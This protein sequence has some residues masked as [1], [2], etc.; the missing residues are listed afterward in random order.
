LK[1]DNICSKLVVFEANKADGSLVYYRT[2][3]GKDYENENLWAYPFYRTFY[4]LSYQET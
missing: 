4:G 3:Q 1:V 2:Y